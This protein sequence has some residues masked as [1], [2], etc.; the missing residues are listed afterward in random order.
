[1]LLLL[2]IS[3]IT[4]IELTGAISC[5]VAHFAALV[6]PNHRMS[7]C[8][9]SVNI[10]GDNSWHQIEFMQ[11][12]QGT[13]R[14]PM[15]WLPW[16]PCWDRASLTHRLVESPLV[17]TTLAVPNSATRPASIDCLLCLCLLPLLVNSYCSCPPFFE[18]SWYI[19]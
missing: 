8:P 14:C 12:R 3:K 10:H 11:C 4:N 5:N 13:L 15:C 2:F 1:M 18:G 7:L 16:S 6:A 19:F 17:S 9:I